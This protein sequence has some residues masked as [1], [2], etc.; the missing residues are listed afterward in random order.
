MSYNSIFQR[1]LYK[2]PISDAICTDIAEIG[3]FCFHH[4]MHYNTSYEQYKL[5]ESAIEEDWKIVRT[6]S[7]EKLQQQ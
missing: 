1:C 4:S 3:N 2:N 6:F 7:R 5:I